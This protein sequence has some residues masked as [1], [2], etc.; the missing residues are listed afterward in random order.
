MNSQGFNYNHVAPGDYYD[1]RS[2]THGFEDMAAWRWWQF[3]LTGEQGEL[4]ELVNAHGGSWNLFP[5][6]EFVTA[7]GRTF[8]ESE[9]RLDGT[10]SCAHVEHLRTEVWWRSIDRRQANSP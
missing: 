5:L 8:I 2:Q 4:P 1:W 6:L 10:T 7:I 3:N 9:S